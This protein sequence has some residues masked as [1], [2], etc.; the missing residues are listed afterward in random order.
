MTSPSITSLLNPNSSASMGDAQQQQQQPQQQPTGPIPYEPSIFN[1]EPIDEFTR[2][3]ADWIW[4]FAG[5]LNWDVVEIEAKI[6]LLVDT[7]MRSRKELPV[8]IETI[9]TDDRGLRFE[10]NM[11]V[12]QHKHFNVLLNSRVEASASP[13]YPHAPVRYNH[14]KEIDGFHHHNGRKLRVTTDQSTGALLRVVE[15]TRVA[16]MNVLS[17]KRGFD[18]RVSVNTETPGPAPP[19]AS[20]AS[21]TRQKD[22]ISY[23][24]QLFQID[25]TQV[26]SGNQPLMHELEVEFRDARALLVEGRKMQDDVPNRYL[27]MV[28]CFLNN[29]R[30]LIR[31]AAEP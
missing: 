3:V 14:S 17:P 21:M 15:K 16:D 11:T 4:A 26:K 22:R 13:N 31:N 1:V 5:D 29:I 27:E 24:H 23:S 18:W 20:Q 25:L 12:G 19:A 28:Q 8:P 6:G 10:S 9:L 7:Q 2:E 30:M